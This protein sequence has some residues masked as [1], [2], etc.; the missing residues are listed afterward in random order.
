MRETE[1]ETPAQTEEG[2]AKSVRLRCGG[3]Q[4]SLCRS[5]LAQCAEVPGLTISGLPVDF[6]PGC[7]CH[8][9]SL[10]C[11]WLFQPNQLC[12]KPQVSRWLRGVTGSACLS[13]PVVLTKSPFLSFQ[14]R[15]PVPSRK[16]SNDN[17]VC[18]MQLITE[19]Q[20]PWREANWLQPLCV[21]V[22]VCVCVSVQARS[23]HRVF[24]Q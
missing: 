23:R 9:N 15:H 18:F 4:T 5:P 8:W 10:I 16:K 11:R 14:L 1:R 13:E 3:A 12:R 24:P 19:E 6:D 22:C 17:K 21:C 7:P 20:F 2:Y